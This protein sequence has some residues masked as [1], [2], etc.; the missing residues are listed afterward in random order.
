MYETIARFYD[1]MMEETDYSLIADRLCGYFKEYG[2]VKTVADIGCGTGRL[3]IE[4]NKRGYDVIGIDCSEDML[5][6]A[7]KNTREAGEDIRFVCQDMCGL[8]IGFEA[9][10]VICTMD[11]INHIKSLSGVL[12]CMKAVRC[13]IRP[14]GLF[15]FDVNTPYKFEKIYADRD[16]VIEQEGVLCAWSNYYFPEEKRN[17]FQLS[18]F[19]KRK[20]GLYERY[21]ELQ[22]EYIYTK[23]ELIE[24]LLRAGLVVKKIE[25]SDPD[26]APGEEERWIFISTRG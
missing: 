24:S 21:D 13:S 22:K 12:A 16:F 8:N 17:D 6:V 20:D 7:E 15:I 1:S 5:A 18:F 14:G 9:D 11:G 3:T 26:S 19:A 2:P 23:K 10:A 25:S 4:L